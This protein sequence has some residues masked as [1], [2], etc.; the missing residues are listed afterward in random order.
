MSVARVSSRRSGAAPPAHL[1]AAL[2]DET[3]LKLVARLSSGGPLSITRLTDGSAVT[4]QAITKHLGVLEHAGLVRGIRVG[5]ERVWEFEPER[6]A[7]ARH[8]LEQISS[9]WDESLGRLKEMVERD[10]P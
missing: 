4:R 6:I 5:R 7:E 2:G 10:R 3:R 1:F 9:Q 8:Y